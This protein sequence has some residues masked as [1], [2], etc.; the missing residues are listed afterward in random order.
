M[1]PDQIALLQEI[2]ATLTQNDA[3]IQI[4]LTKIHQGIAELSKDN[5]KIIT[6]LQGKVIKFLDRTVTSHDNELDRV[7]TLVLRGLQNW[8]NDNRLM[9]TQ[10]AAKTGL[11][12][13]GDPLEAALVERVAEAPDLAYSATLLLALREFQ[14]PLGRLIEVLE[15]IRDRL[16]GAPVQVP[17]E[18]PDNA[19][20]AGKPDLGPIG[21]YY[22]GPAA[23]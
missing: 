5:A 20:M 13:P 16:P 3:A 21:A 23:E 2:E 8:Q 17:G 9:L 6:K 18:L 10:L 12:A 7:Q 14:R 19:K 15:E 4:P 1:T 22:D 11:T